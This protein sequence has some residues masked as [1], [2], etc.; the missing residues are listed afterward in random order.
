VSYYSK[1]LLDQLRQLK[2]AVYLRKSTQDREDK[3]LRSIQGQREDLQNLI[4]LHGLN[5][6]IEFEEKQSAF[7]PGRPYYKQMLEM[8]RKNEANACLVWHP[9]RISRNYRD[10][11]EFVQLMSD[12]KLKL[13]LTPYSIFE[14]NPRDKEYLMS[15][16]TRATRD[17]DEKSEAIKR[18]NRTKL[19]EGYIPSGRLPE[20]YIHVKNEKGMMIN[21]T[22]PKRFPLLQKAIQLVLDQTHTPIEALDALNCEWGYRT[23]IT[24]L[25]GDSPLSE[26]TWYKILS[27]E[28]YTGDLTQYG[29]YDT[30]NKASFKPLVSQQ[31]FNRIQ[32]LLGKKST[33]RKN[34]HVR[35]YNGHIKCG[36]CEGSI[37]TEEK[38]QIICSECKNKFHKSKNRTSCPKCMVEIEEMK[39]PT[40]LHYEWLVCGKRKKK[41]NNT[42]CSQ[43]TITVQEFEKQI[44]HTLS[45]IEISKTFVD[46]ALTWLSKINDSEVSERTSIYQNLQKLFNNTQTQIDKLLDMRIK[47][48]IDDNEYNDK[49]KMLLSERSDLENKLKSTTQR[50]DN[51]LDMAEKTFHFASQAR[52]L[53]KTG[54]INQK[55]LV[56]QTISPNL[57]LKDKK[58]AIDLTEPLFILKNAKKEVE[59]LDPKFEPNILTDTSEYK[60][61]FESS[62]PRLIPN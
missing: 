22:D 42:K 48:L 37:I 27:S 12:K 7:H 18:G 21:K 19:K 23:K 38:W 52:S 3:Q 49:K 1:E 10:G 58:I 46:W 6:V 29:E 44:D 54:D 51:W 11:G 56:L 61:A 8:F 4:Q 34:K 16:F 50:A 60:D 33:R 26:S 35:I 40:I 14:N 45:E 30:N 24:P 32:I 13:V 15:E 41:I 53:F 2:F 39:K 57:T 62:I 43:K 36:E 5:V 28:V 55:R 17:S 47:G 31:D 59:I 20:G 9:N 25:G